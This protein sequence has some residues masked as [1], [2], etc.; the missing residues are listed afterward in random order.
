M[1]VVEPLYLPPARASTD[2][3]IA[4]G[5]FKLYP[6]QRLLEEN[7]E[8]VR[9]GSRAFELLLTLVEQKGAI[10]SKAEL[11]ERVWPDT[12]V[13]EGSLR[14]SMA[15]VKKALGQERADASYIKNVPGKGYC[16]V[17][18]ITDSENI[19][20]DSP[21]GATRRGN[22]P[23]VPIR[24]IGRTE[25]IRSISAELPLNRFLTIVGSGGVGKTTVAI[26]A[27]QALRGGYEERAYLVDLAPL[28][29]P[30]HVLTT[31]CSSLGLGAYSDNAILGLASY[32]NDRRML[33]VLDNCE[34][35]IE[36]VAH[37]AEEILKAAEPSYP[38]DE[39]GAVARGGRMGATADA[40]EISR[41]VDR[42]FSAGG[43]CLSGRRAI[44]R[45]GDGEFPE[46]RIERSERKDDLLD[47]SP[48]RRHSPGDRIRRRPH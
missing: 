28:Q 43:A 15:A 23:N 26:A 20:L 12:N 37:A 42:A 22:I 9:L 36:A 39:P 38:G 2:R 16:F 48:A 17:A 4:F 5:R 31:I 11:I 44:C 14:V 13:E 18:P 10:L 35:V 8:P 24:S 27:A 3:A 34:H 21:A 46:L 40:V 45:P 32:L 19:R 47:L 6:R 1:M 33:I 41:S 30:A 29:N 7:G 25:F